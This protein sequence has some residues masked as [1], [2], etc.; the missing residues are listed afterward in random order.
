MAD[1]E[2]LAG[3]G[4]KTM[5]AEETDTEVP[6]LEV[7]PHPDPGWQYVGR[8]GGVFQVHDDGGGSRATTTEAGGGVDDARTG[9]GDADSDGASFAVEAEFGAA[10][11][12]SESEDRRL[13][14]RIRE[15]WKECQV[16]EAMIKAKAKAKA[17]TRHGGGSAVVG[18]PEFWADVDRRGGDRF[19]TFGAQQTMAPRGASEQVGKAKTSGR[20]ADEVFYDW[21]GE[22]EGALPDVDRPEPVVATARVEMRDMMDFQAALPVGGAMPAS[23]GDTGGGGSADGVADGVADGGMPTAYKRGPAGR[24]DRTWP[25]AAP[26]MLRRTPGRAVTDFDLPGAP[27]GSSALPRMWR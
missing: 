22:A 1:R 27:E 24:R 18:L 12:G 16:K 19:R 5:G 4:A 26:M 17:K 23:V 7:A 11:A 25:R 20:K 9:L 3:G 13:I 15:V 21:N 8:A 2:E 6:I 14:A 10:L